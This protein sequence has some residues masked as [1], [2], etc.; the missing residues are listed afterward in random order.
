MV[1]MCSP[2]REAMEINSN[3]ERR[4]T[5]KMMRVTIKMMSTKSKMKSFSLRII[6]KEKGEIFKGQIKDNGILITTKEI[7]ESIVKEIGG[8]TTN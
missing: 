1:F 5:H 2:R 6:I 4:Y 8:T 7:W 3:H